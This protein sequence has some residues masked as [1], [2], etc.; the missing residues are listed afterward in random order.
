MTTVVDQ[1]MTRLCCSRPL[2]VQLQHESV[3][4][5]LR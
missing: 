2:F 1:A 5:Q 4:V 3:Y